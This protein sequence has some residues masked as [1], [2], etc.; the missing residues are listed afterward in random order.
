MRRLVFPFVALVGAFAVAHWTDLAAA[1]RLVGTA[2]LAEVVLFLLA[3]RLRRGRIAAAVLVIAL[4]REA[5]ARWGGGPTESAA[6]VTLAI[7]VLVPLN[8]GL[9]SVMREFWVT[10]R[11][12]AI[13]FALLATQAIA[14]WALTHPS[15]APVLDRIR[16]GR[17]ALDGHAPSW[18]GLPAVDP[19]VVPAVPA[20]ALGVLPFSMLAM[21]L[22]AILAAFG[23][24][25]RRSPLEAGLLAALGS[26]AWALLAAPGPFFLLAAVLVLAVG[27]VENA[28]GLAFH[29]G[30]TG[31]PARRALEE[32]LGQLGR[33]YTL[34]M[35]D[36]DHFKKLNDRHGH[37]VGD[38]VLRLVATLLRRVGG[39]G[40]AFRY[41]GEEFTVVFPGR[42]A[43][44]AK[45][46]LDALCR[47][48]AKTPFIVRSPGRPTSKPKGRSKKPTATTKTLKVTVSIGAAERSDKAPTPEV[49][50][51]AADKA[52]YKSKKA[53]RNRVTLG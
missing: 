9:L 1:P 37:E 19:T 17:L 16:A 27:L 8:L 14:A 23:L 44:E 26:A 6:I 47:E 35:V 21:V 11:A 46:T 42:S 52:L 48:I 33:T 12:G 30:L 38:Q 43:D 22:G 34:A 32:R 7:G 13:R 5:L 45:S 53:G 29:D 18:L 25:R 31:L 40:E 51:K 20:D 36:L 50:L 41:G 3:W 15:A 28:V 4:A 24:W 39:G 2:R 49:V 10:S